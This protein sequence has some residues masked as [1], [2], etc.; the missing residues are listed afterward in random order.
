MNNIFFSF[1]KLTFANL[2]TL[3]NL[4]ASKK[5]ATKKVSNQPPKNY[6]SPPFDSPWN[7]LQFPDRPSNKKNYLLNLSNFNIFKKSSTFFY[8]IVQS[9]IY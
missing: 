1:I 7:N 2:I 9:T 5:Y 3:K 6:P 8:S 4:S